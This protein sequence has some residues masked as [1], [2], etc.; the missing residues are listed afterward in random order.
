MFRKRLFPGHTCLKLNQTVIK[1]RLLPNCRTALHAAITFLFRWNKG[2]RT[3]WVIIATVVF[4]FLYPSKTAKVLCPFMVECTYHTTNELLLQLL[5]R[6]FHITFVL[7]VYTYE[8]PKIV[9]KSNLLF[10]ISY[11]SNKCPCSRSFVKAL[12]RPIIEKKIVHF[13]CSVLSYIILHRF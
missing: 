5:Y 7:T 13:Q 3:T 4:L 11:S 2:S 9:I 8:C 1:M 6:N 12:W 10:T